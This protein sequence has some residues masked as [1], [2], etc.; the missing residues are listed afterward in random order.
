MNVVGVLPSPSGLEAEP[1]VP[2]K[3][4]TRAQAKENVD[5]ANEE[6]DQQSKQGETTSVSVRTGRGKPNK[7]KQKQNMSKSKQLWQLSFPRNSQN[8]DDKSDRKGKKPKPSAGLVPDLLGDQ[9]NV[10]ATKLCRAWGKVRDQEVLVFF[11]PGA[12][13]NFISPELASK[14]GIR[15]EEMGMTGEVGLACPGHSEAVTPILGKLRLHIQSYVDAEQFHIMPLQDCDVLLSIPWMDGNKEEGSSSEDRQPIPTAHEI[16]EST[17]QAEKALQVVTVVTMFKQLTE[18]PRFMEFIQSSSIAHQVQE[19]AA[20]QPIPILPPPSLP[21]PPASPVITPSTSH[22]IP[23]IQPPDV[24]PDH[25][26]SDSDSDLDVADATPEVD[27]APPRR[28]KR[29]PGWLY[30]TIASSGVTELPV[31]PP[32]GLP[33]RSAKKRGQSVGARSHLAALLKLHPSF[34]IVTLL[35]PPFSK[36]DDLKPILHS[37]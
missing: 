15:T 17:G 18:N 23:P 13:A 16:S 4:V 19:G 21:D 10:N 28:E 33:R 24:S 3:V 8:K 31:P 32:A 30:S 34:T 26:L 1:K 36:D 11:D 37:L 27:S 22:P 14:L 7:R 5:Q 2:V 9:Q 35:A 12:R 6:K 29:I 25:A 20:T